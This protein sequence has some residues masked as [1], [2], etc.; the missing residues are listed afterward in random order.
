M[1]SGFFKT[2]PRDGRNPEKVVLGPYRY[3]QAKGAENA[4]VFIYTKENY[5]LSPNLF[6]S[7]DFVKE[8]QLSNTNPQQASYN[9]GT[10]ELFEWTTPRGFKGKGVLY[11]QHLISIQCSSPDSIAL[12]H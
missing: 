9:W 12:E 6:V 7:K 11:K 2:N 5:E 8:T 1:E 3:A 10:A 4:E